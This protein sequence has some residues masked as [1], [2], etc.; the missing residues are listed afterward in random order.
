MPTDYVYSY[1]ANKSIKLADSM[2]FISNFKKSKH[3]DKIPEGIDVIRKPTAFKVKM[4]SKSKDKYSRHSLDAAPSDIS[5]AT[6]AKIAKTIVN[7]FS[8][9]SDTTSNG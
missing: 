7:R 6:S 9:N 5:I 4:K 3:S 8:K 1:S 2:A